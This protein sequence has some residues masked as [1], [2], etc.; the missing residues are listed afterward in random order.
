[1]NLFHRYARRTLRKNPIRTLVTMIGIVL[2]MALF[3]AVLEGANSG[4]SFLIRS[5]EE[6]TGK[7]HGYAASLS[8]EEAGRLAGEPE[9]ERTASWEEVGW[10]GIES[11]N[12]YKPYLVIWSAGDGLTDLL[13]VNLIEGRLPENENEILLPAHLSF[14]GGVEIKTGEEITLRVGRREAGGTPLSE[15]Q[16]F[17]GDAGPTESIV[18]AKERTYRVT[19]FYRRFDNAVEPFSS[20]GYFALTRG[21]GDG[22]KG[23]FFTVKAPAK[24]YD[25]AERM[26]ASGMEDLR[27]NDELLRCLGGIRGSNLRATL[28]GFSAILCFLIAF[29]SI[30]LIYNAFAISVSERTREYGVLKSVG[31]TKKQIASSVFYEALLMAGAGIPLGALLGLAGIGITLRCLEG[32]FTRLLFEGSATRMGL[33]VSFP[34][35]FSAAAVCLL[36]TLLSAWIPA[37]RAMRVSP[38]DAIR[39]TADVKIRTKEVKTSRL[40]GKL[41]GLEGV[42]AS[43]N[44][45]RNRKR[46]RATIL[47]LFLSVVLFISASAFTAYLATALTDMAGRDPKSDAACYSPPEEEGDREELF[48]LLPDLRSLPGVTKTSYTESVTIYLT[49]DRKD[50]SSDYGYGSKAP[51]DRLP[52]DVT[53]GVF[54]VFSE[55]GEFRELLANN[56]LKEEGFFDPAHPRGLLYNHVTIRSWTEKEGSHWAS[57][58]F[59]DPGKTPLT[60]REYKVIPPEGTVE[61][62]D[63]ED[64]NGNRIYCFLPLEEYER[65]QKEET[66]PDEKKIIRLSREEATDASDYEVAGIAKE[67]LIAL[68]PGRPALIYPLSVRDAVMANRKTAENDGLTARV[69]FLSSDH[70]RT[71]KEAR[72]LIE[73]RGLTASAADL[74]EDRDT[75]ALLL[76]TVNVF[77]YGFITLISLIAVANVFNSV[78]TGILLRR[79]EFAMM[80]SIGLS[81][82]GFRKMMRYECLLYGIKSLLW[83][84]PASFLMTYLIW[85]ITEN[86]L[87]IRFFIPWGSVL[88]AVGSVF[89]VV[90]VTMLY[91]SAK[92]KK[93]NLIDVIKRET[94]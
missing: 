54:L 3:T 94:L 76:A 12:E 26:T 40:T 25:F 86:S 11:K 56:G 36:T 44:F 60:L 17:S 75:A 58:S 5:I 22:R 79:R 87:S 6:A 28:Y 55:D 35:L 62:G 49:A 33:A 84:L 50:A 13:S 90:F 68:E 10:A 4:M 23:L 71:V 24:Y 14:D 85:K 80:R 74:A 48:A 51:E 8:E 19:G 32:T 57:F 29:G 83:G 66:P 16:P 46:Y 93:D 18:G 70:Q 65:M 39:A 73:D 59:V 47:S 27:S 20:P 91:A 38:M 63:E 61:F 69:D 72:K 53:E 78:S 45:K 89:L 34:M 67:T 7:F 37:R 77:S 30:S 1:M 15:K 2:S 81:E 43:K 41:F 52:A 82:R 31:A 92:I 88:I 21:A 9:I 64:E 42:L